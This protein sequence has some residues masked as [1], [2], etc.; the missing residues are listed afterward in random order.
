MFV[1]HEPKVNDLQTSRVKINVKYHIQ[2]VM[3]I[4]LFATDK[5]DIDSLTIE[6][7]EIENS[8]W[9]RVDMEFLFECLTR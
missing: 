2:D 8:T 6:D 7:C 3:F 5:K 9:A 4:L 1:T